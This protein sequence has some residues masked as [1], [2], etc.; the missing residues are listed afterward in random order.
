MVDL[1]ET[2][3]TVREVDGDSS[4]FT[5]SA[6]KR[7]A[8]P[9]VNNGSLVVA[10]ASEGTRSDRPWHQPGTIESLTQQAQLLSPGAL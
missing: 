2:N 1:N 9:A 10:C 7:Y 3:H 5:L 6:N 8:M 4:V